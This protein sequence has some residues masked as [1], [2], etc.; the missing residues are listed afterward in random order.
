MPQYIIHYQPVA[1]ANVV[2][3][4]TTAPGAILGSASVCMGA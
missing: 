4:V 3:T 2:V 1:Q